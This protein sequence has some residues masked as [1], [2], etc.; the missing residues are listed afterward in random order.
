[1]ILFV[2]KIIYGI[3]RRLPPAVRYALSRLAACWILRF[4]PDR[5]RVLIDNLAPLVGKERAEHLAPELLGNFLQ[6]ASDLFCPPASLA[7]STTLENWSLL[8]EAYRKTQRLIALT[9]HIGHW[10]LGVSCLLNK[11]YAVTGLYAA[12]TDPAI[13]QWIHRH[14]DHRA[15]WFPATHG[16]AAACVAAVEKKRVVA[17][18]GDIPF[19]ERGRRVSIAGHSARLPVGP[20]AI[21]VRTQATVIPAFILRERPG[22]YR[23]IIHPE[24]ERPEGSFRYQI[25]TMQDAYAKLLE[26]YLQAYPEQ[27]GVLQ[28]FWEK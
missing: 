12:Y 2:Y 14:R 25:Q 21:A 24:I 5:R 20:W 16:A 8:D 10:E 13:V 27:W 11:G 26:H 15:E 9:A 19:G 18:V 22:H 7:S 3:T 28:P 23:C 4:I 1:M 17:L 6:T